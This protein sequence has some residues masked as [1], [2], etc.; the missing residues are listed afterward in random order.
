VALVRAVVVAVAAIALTACVGPAR[1]TSVYTDKAHKTAQ[2]AL[3]QLE[4]ARLAVETSARGSLQDAYLQTVLT[5]AE[6]AI[7]SIQNTFDSIQPPDTSASDALRDELDELLGEASDG[8]A[9][10][11]IAARRGDTDSLTATA[12]DLESTAKQLQEF[13]EKTA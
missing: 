12:K 11:R 9:T 13:S 2:D 3:S 8:M 7:S 5:D 4:T 6:D 10:L 1:T